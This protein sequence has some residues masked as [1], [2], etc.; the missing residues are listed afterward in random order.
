MFE[1]YLV[2][3]RG[4]ENV[5]EGGKAIGFQLKIRISYYRGVFLALVGDIHV[6]VDGESY[7]SGQ[8]RF[9]IGGRTYKM[10][11]LAKQEETRW[12]FGDPATLTILKPGGLSPGLHEVEL[13]ESIKPSYMPAMG[14][15]GRSKRKITLV[16]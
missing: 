6:T 3:T 8:M 2:M 14:F 12:P 10:D 7:S 9:T 16:A 15:V 11:E 13:V 1:K 4:F 5:M